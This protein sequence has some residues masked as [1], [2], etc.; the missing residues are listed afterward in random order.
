MIK[1]SLFF[2]YFQTE[3]VAN[4]IIE[5]ASLNNYPDSLTTA[6]PPTTTRPPSQNRFP[7]LQQLFSGNSNANF[8]LPRGQ[9]RYAGLGK[10][11]F[12]FVRPVGPMPTRTPV[13]A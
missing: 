6:P 13:V 9:G 3:D 7:N 8:G 4:D 2:P 11:P 5:S 12:F 1:Y 10:T